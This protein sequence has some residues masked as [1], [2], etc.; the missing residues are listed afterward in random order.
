MDARDALAKALYGRLFD[1]LVMR[2]NMSIAGHHGIVPDSNFI[3]VLD[4]FGFE[5]FKVSFI[6]ITYLLFLILNL[7]FY[8]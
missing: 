1:W 7:S 8:L 3:G 5:N 2:I 4:I 6:F